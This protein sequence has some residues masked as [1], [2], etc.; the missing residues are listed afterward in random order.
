MAGLDGWLQEATR[1]LTKDS[2]AQV[3]SEIRE[4]YESVRDARLADG[5]TAENADHMALAALGDPH[6]VNCR[7]REAMLTSADARLLRESNLEARF[8]CSRPGLRWTGIA[9]LALVTFWTAVA[10]FFLGRIEP[11]QIAAALF[12]LTGL[13]FVA[14][15]LPIYTPSRSRVYRWVK[16]ALFFGALVMVL[17]HDAFHLSW[18]LFSCLWPMVWVE[19]RRMAL[20]RK[21]PVA[22]WPRQLFL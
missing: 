2:A 8:F 3:R 11:S 21:L 15:Q 4:H 7:Y 1:H 16:W 14:P 5:A 17:G 9:A 19:R 10:L 6:I 22:A 12:V 18:L 13:L 20:R